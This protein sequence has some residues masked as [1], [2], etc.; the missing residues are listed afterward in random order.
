MVA[1]TLL[2]RSKTPLRGTV[3]CRFPAR[4]GRR[5]I[6]KPVYAVRPEYTV[7]DEGFQRDVDVAKHP[8]EDD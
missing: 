6:G 3:P 8:G 4:R 5:G 1:R 2:V 7:Q